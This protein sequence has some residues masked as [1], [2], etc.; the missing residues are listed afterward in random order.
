MNNGE[1]TGVLIVDLSKAFDLVD[2][3]ISDPV[4]NKS[5]VPQGSVLGL[6]FFILFIN[7]LNYLLIIPLI[8]Q[9]SNTKLL[10]THIDSSLT[11]DV[12][13]SHIK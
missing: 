5:G 1:L 2:G 9:I 3:I 12:Q 8:E 7:T 11:W 4:E 6:L 10:C 13:V